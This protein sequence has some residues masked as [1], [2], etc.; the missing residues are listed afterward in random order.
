VPVSLIPIFGKNCSFLE[1][2]PFLGK[3]RVRDLGLSHAFRKWAKQSLD[4]RESIRI[5]WRIFELWHPFSGKI[6]NLECR[7]FHFWNCPKTVLN[8]INATYVMF[9]VLFRPKFGLKNT[10]YDPNVVIDRNV[11]NSFRTVSFGS[12]L[13]HFYFIFAQIYLQNLNT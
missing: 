13:V 4:G 10:A 2:C 5:W 6:P 7:F 1:R 8:A 12:F 3:G 11:K 9:Y